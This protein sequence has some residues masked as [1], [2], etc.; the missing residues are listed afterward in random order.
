MDAGKQ[1]LR[2]PNK[3]DYLHSELYLITHYDSVKSVKQNPYA[4]SWTFSDC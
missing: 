2:D 1:K 4:L 3:P